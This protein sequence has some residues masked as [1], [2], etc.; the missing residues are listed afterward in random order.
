MKK[1]LL[2]AMLAMLTMGGIFAKDKNTKIEE[3][4][5]EVTA[6]EFFNENFTAKKGTVYKLTN[7][8]LI[9][10]L[11][12]ELL[13]N[14]SGWLE[15]WDSLSKTL[16]TEEKNRIKIVEENDEYRSLKKKYIVYV[17]TNVAKPKPKDLKV[18]KVENIP[19]ENDFVKIEEEKHLAAEREAEEQRIASERFKKD[20]GYAYLP[21]GTTTEVFLSVNKY[22]KREKDEGSLVVY[23]TEG[24][25]EKSKM[26]YKFLDNK[27]VAGMTRFSNTDKETGEAIIY[28]LKELYGQQTSDKVTKEHHVE[29]EPDLGTRISYTEHHMKMF[30]EKSQTFRITL[31]ARVLVGDSKKDDFNINMFITTDVSNMT[32]YYDN[33]SMAAQISASDAKAKKEKEA[34]KKAQEEADFRKKMNSLGL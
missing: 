18:I 33:P 24:A 16:T 32:V 23:S 15:Y 10:N 6:D 14:C 21:W 9:I 31:D 17:Q 11:N 19:T 29:T 13:T 2:M 22:S 1:I 30:W 12:G 25:R 34:A 7:V 28:R 5:I 8:N 4:A 26:F 20:G 27:L 3:S